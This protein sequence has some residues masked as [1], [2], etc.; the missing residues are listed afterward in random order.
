M[1]GT[2]L[3]AS[4]GTGGHVFP[5]VAVAERLSE[6]GYRPVLITDRR[7]Y[8]IARGIGTITA[9]HR[10]LAA[11]PYGGSLAR[12]L[13]GLAK[14]GLGLLQSLLLMGRYRP[15]AVIGFG[16]YPSVA[17]VLLGRLLGRATMVHEQNAFFGRANAFL[18]RFAGTIALSWADTANIP[19]GGTD[20][21]VLT[22]MPVRASFPGIG[23]SGYTPP[24]AGG[25]TPVNLLV[26]G[27]SLGARVFGD[28]VAEAISRLPERLRRRLRVAH[29]VREEQLEAVRALYSRT[30]IEADLRPF[31]DDMPGAV[32]DAHL[33][34]CRAGASSV[35]ELAA[36]GRPAILVPFPGAMDDHQRFNADTVVAAGGGWCVPEDGLGADALAARIASL[37]DEPGRLSKAAAAML[38]MG[39]DDAARDICR[40]LQTAI[41]GGP[42]A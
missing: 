31:I 41:E 32:R 21:A 34:I 38:A 22:G 24:D 25:K 2:V 10:I 4:G 29:Q 6:V 26:V 19:G 36:S 7:G 30:G 3:L 39:R 16:G 11:S 5:A 28:T 13:L 12:R 9:I 8:G 17:P 37:V 33:V 27:G 23:R 15:A 20:K 35:A 40:H 1:T 14:L 42:R 18:A